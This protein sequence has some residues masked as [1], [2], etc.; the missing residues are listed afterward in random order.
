MEHSYKTYLRIVF[1]LFSLL[2]ACSV[3]TSQTLSDGPIEIIVRVRDISV[4]APET[5]IS[6]FGIVGQPDD[7][8]FKLWA[9]D[10][11]D[12]DGMGWI[13]GDCLTDDVLLLNH[14]KD[15][16]HQIFQHLYA[17]ATVPRY[18]DLRLDAWEDEQPDQL[19]GV[20]CG[21]SRCEYD[22]GFC[23]GGLLFGLCL[24]VVDDDDFRCNSGT[25]IP[26]V[27]N[28]DYRLGNPCQW[29]NHGYLSGSCSNDYYKPR[30]E[31]YWRYTNGDAI[32]NP[33]ELGTLTN[34][35]LMA[36]LNSNECYS[37]AYPASAGKD[38]FYGFTTSKDLNIGLSLCTGTAFDSQVFLLNSNGDVLASNDDFCGT[39]SALENIQI[40][41]GQYTIVV[42]GKNAADAGLFSLKLETTNIIWHVKPAGNDFN[43]GLAWGTAFQTLQQALLVA[44][45]GD[46]IWAAE[47]TYKPTTGTDRSIS[48]VMKNGVAILGG[49]PN[50]GNPDMGDRD[51]AANQTILSGDL[52]GDD[53]PNF[54]N[55]GDNSQHVISNFYNYLDSTA[56]LDGFTVTGGYAECCGG[57]N[58]YG[59]GMLNVFASP[60]VR[61]CIFSRNLA[62]FGGGM[63]NIT[64]SFSLTNCV[65]QGNSAS[66]GGGINLQEG[67]NSVLTNCSFNG[68]TSE[69]GGAIYISQSNPELTSCIVWGNDNGLQFV[70]GGDAT[71]RYSIVQ[72]PSGVYPGVGNLNVDP[73]FVSTGDLRLQ[74]CSPAIDA[75]DDSANNTPLDLGGNPRKTDVYAGGTQ[76][77]MGA[78]EAGSGDS[79]PPSITCPSPTTVSCAGNV[80]APNTASVNATD[81]C[82]VTGKEHVFSIPSNI[83]CA[84]RFSVLRVY[85]AT[86]GLGN[87][88]T[89]SQVITVFD[90]T[91]PVF[92]FTPANVTVQCNSVPAVG[93]PTASD[94]C[95][96][97]VGIAYNGQNITSGSCSD[98]Y[99]LTRQWTATDACGNTRTA[100]QRITVIDTQK[101]AFTGTPANITVQC[102]AV[103]AAGTPTATDNCDAVVAITYNSQTQT[104]GSCPNAY[105]LTR[106]WTAADNCGNTVSVS[107]RITV[108]DNDKPVFTSFPANTTIACNET[109]PPA[110]SPTASD[111]CGSVTV[112]YLGQ[113]TT[114]G[115]CPGNYQIKR[116]WRATDA[117]GNS[118]VSTQTIQ[119]SDTG[120]PVFT[121]AP[122]PLTIECNQ[123]LPPLMN[124]TASDACGGYAAITFLGNAPS[125]SG[126]ATDYTVTRTWKAEDLCG[127]SATTAQVITVLGNSYG[128]PGA[129]NREESAA[130]LIAYRSSL[131]VNPNPTTDRFWLDLSDFAGEAV[132]V[133]IASNLGRLVWERRIPTVEDLNL[134]VS[135]REAGAAAGIYTISVY[136]ASGVAATRV[137]LVE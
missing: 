92:T 22:V 50:S 123:P 131:L 119:V 38:V 60:D 118:T 1:G 93:T 103:P 65:F 13:G 62:F 71:I 129:E 128:G 37:N 102:D 47:G 94:N 4:T 35:A 9:R 42:S 6:V 104:S 43:D 40:P 88:S 52:T 137:V 120:V 101:P 10:D 100:T 97:S 69:F 32:G 27:D 80:P 130:G 99:T 64:S 75:G 135:L 30:I 31:T 63:Y 73:L 136:S 68:N 72:K 113:S 25:T 134:L 111:G 36:P 18:L 45:A 34:G 19:L 20:G 106:R 126:C 67:S 23:C 11:A 74:S 89:C 48:F 7:Y 2:G 12:Q 49:F 3:S 59:G 21:G 108:T 57:Y 96:G 16:N 55:Y 85:R 79:E 58:G 51:W 121:S 76:I 14:T 17:S 98:A 112:T 24:G 84:N 77:D 8:S 5:D 107:Q 116:T 44:E 28:L 122:G 39:Q 15:F 46:S 61:N 83:V 105:T 82:V 132:T 110:G 90:S 114:S 54:A 127:N 78:Y 56:V 86:D 124:P 29:Y 53:G 95:G 26:F 109:P 81:N 91:L 70:S 41:A 133:S 117:C 87:S 115:N 125:G 33:I 66:N